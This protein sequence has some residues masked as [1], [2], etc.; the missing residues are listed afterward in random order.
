MCGSATP[1]EADSLMQ[2]FA[3]LHSG[4]GHGPSH[5]DRVDEAMS[6]L[7]V[8]YFRPQYG[9]DDVSSN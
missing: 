3:V 2:A 1:E 4:E 8:P 7:A 5:P 9:R 6:M